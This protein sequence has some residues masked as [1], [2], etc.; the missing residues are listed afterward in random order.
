MDTGCLLNMSD[1]GEGNSGHRYCED[2]TEYKLTNIHTGEVVFKNRMQMREDLKI[3]RSSVCCLM[4]GRKRH[5]CGW[6]LGD[7]PDDFQ[8]SRLSPYD[9]H[10]LIHRIT[11][12]EERGTLEDLRLSTGL[13]GK[14]ISS[15]VHGKKQSICGW[16][17]ETLEGKSFKNH[18]QSHTIIN[19]I[20]KEIFTGTQAEIKKKIDSL[21]VTHI[22]DGKCIKMW[23]LGNEVL[24]ETEIRF[25]KDKKFLLKNKKTGEERML[26]VNE[27]QDIGA[28]SRAF[29]VMRREDTFKGWYRP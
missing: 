7:I 5:A 28:K 4:K 18:G 2:P 10:T 8:Y 11:M 17:Y 20:S 29:G 21:N 16:V 3:D 24:E 23:V 12:E 25:N 13:T 15:L 1:G 26:C 14:Q 22:L 27:L 6:Y 19:I 9:T